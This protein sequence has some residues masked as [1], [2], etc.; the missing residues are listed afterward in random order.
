ML[1][2]SVSEQFGLHGYALV[3]EACVAT[4]EIDRAGLCEHSELYEGIG[5]IRGVVIDLRERWDAAEPVKL[6]DADAD[7][8][9]SADVAASA[10]G[11]WD[12]LTDAAK[13]LCWRV[14]ATQVEA[15]GEPGVG[16][17]THC[18]HGRTTISQEIVD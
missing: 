16:T 11:A 2:N 1:K 8:V 3:S 10:E 7:V 14:G 9:L 6:A 13:Q 15:D 4:L 5:E 12:A 18:V 17:K